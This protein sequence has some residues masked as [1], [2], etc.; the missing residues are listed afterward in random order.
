MATNQEVLEKITTNDLTDGA[1][2]GE[3]FDRFF[4]DVQG[5]TDVLDRTRAVSVTAESGDIPRLSI[6]PQTMTA[7]SEGEEAPLSNV[8]QPSVHYQTQKVSIA[9]QLTW[10]AANE[11]VDNFTE[12]VANMLSE[13]FA[14][15]LE[16][17]ASVGD[18]STTG[19]T[20]INDGWITLA[21]NKGSP[22]YDHSG[23]PDG[24]GTVTA[25]PIDKSLFAGMI[26]K[27][28]EKYQEANPEPVFLMS[29][30]QKFAYEESLSQRNTGAGD[31]L[32]MSQ[33]EPKGYGHDILTPLMW[34]DDTVMLTSPQNLVYVVQDRMRLE[35]SKEGKEMTLKDLA[36]VMNMLAKVD[37][38]I[39]DPQGVVVGT[40]V[41][42]P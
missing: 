20:A 27:L 6:A 24:D 12:A 39:M 29:K 30:Q 36:V 5:Q 4:R 33:Q 31:A 16:R 32:L 28:P 18:T 13:G 25:Q 26:K 8:E 14:Q 11:T 34:P 17:V 40:G 1:L 9:T 15:D 21:E 10:E 23:D 3:N 41:A 22:T 37:Y 42:A 2:V 35:Q 7:V 19:F 38:Q